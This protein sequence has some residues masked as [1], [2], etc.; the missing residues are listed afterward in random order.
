[1]GASFFQKRNYFKLAFFCE[2]MY[3]P[4]RY[5][6]SHIDNCPFCGKIAVTKNKQGVPV[7]KSHIGEKLKDIKCA[8][9]EWLDLQEGK[10]GSYFKCMRCGNISFKK[11]I[12][13]NSNFKSTIIQDK[14]KNKE[15][16]KEIFVR[17]DQ[18][19]SLY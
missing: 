5:G 2:S 4:K 10:F 9:G 6:E 17:S 7:C 3:I 1:L 14:T 12:E 11:A 16:R 8:C 19:D 13:M 18:L 15:P